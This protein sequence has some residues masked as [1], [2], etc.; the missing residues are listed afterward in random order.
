M[1]GGGEDAPWYAAHSA[2]D[3]LSARSSWDSVGM[4]SLGKCKTSCSSVERIMS[5]C[6]REWVAEYMSGYA[7]HGEGGKYAEQLAH[8]AIHPKTTVT[9]PTRT[10]A[11]FQPHRRSRGR[12]PWRSLEQTCLRARALVR[13]SEPGVLY[14]SRNV[15]HCSFSLKFAVCTQLCSSKDTGR[16]VEDK[17]GV[18][19]KTEEA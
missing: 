16:D 9:H 5:K 7:M 15:W 8:V 4:M 1:Y 18:E 13:R 17:L 11:H 3:R 6:L 12:L 2:N 10:V 14:V 19:C